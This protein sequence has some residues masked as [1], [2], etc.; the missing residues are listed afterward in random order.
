MLLQIFKFAE[1]EKDAFYNIVIIIVQTK[2]I[3]TF[4]ATFETMYFRDSLHYDID[5]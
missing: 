3:K 5:F 2:C 1:F 4:I